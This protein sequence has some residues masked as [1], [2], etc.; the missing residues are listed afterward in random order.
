MVTK[1]AEIFS[2]SHDAKS[3]GG[4]MVVMCVL[5]GK[6]SAIQSE[7]R[8]PWMTASPGA[9]FLVSY[10]GR[11]SS[12]TGP[13]PAGST[14]WHH[15]RSHRRSREKTQPHASVK[16]LGTGHEQ[17]PPNTLQHRTQTI[18]ARARHSGAGHAALGTSRSRVVRSLTLF[19]LP[20]QTRAEMS[21]PPKSQN[22]TWASQNITF[23]FTRM[24]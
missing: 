15:I 21:L 17:Q 3:Q 2:Q 16:D 1:G 22:P 13:C 8:L 7:T 12:R 23:P 6:A 5:F 18:F 9:G 24:G 10:I 11:G 14:S 4:R 19:H 20:R